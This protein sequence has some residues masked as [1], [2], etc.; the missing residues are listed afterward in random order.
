VSEEKGGAVLVSEFIKLIGRHGDKELIIEVGF[1]DFEVNGLVDMP[2]QVRVHLK[3]TEAHKQ[4]LKRL[5]GK[6]GSE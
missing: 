1:N 5:G 4:T 2:D 6:D 3:K